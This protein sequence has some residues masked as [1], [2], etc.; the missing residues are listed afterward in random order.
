MGNNNVMQVETKPLTG[1]LK[2]QSDLMNELNVSSENNG[3][4]FTP[5]GK[6]CVLNAI[7]GLVAMTTAQGI[8][9]NKLNAPLLKMALQNVG[10]TELNYSAI[11][12]EVYFDLR[13]VRKD[14]GSVSYVPSIKPQGAGNEKLLR[15][16][17][18][19]LVKDTGL[20]TAWLIREG[21]DYTLPSFN[22]LEMTPPTWT[23]KSFDKKVIMVVYPAQKTDGTVE[24]LYATREGIKPNIIAQI[25]QNTMYAFQKFDGKQKVT[26]EEA[27]N[28]FYDELNK[29]AETHSVDEIIDNPTYAAYINP[30]YTSGG[31]KEQMILRKMK[32]NALKNYPKEY[33]SAAQRDAVE[34]MWEDNDDSLKEKPSVAKDVVAKVEHEINEEP[35]ADAIK[36][37]TV[38]EDGVVNAEN[39][40]PAQTEAPAAETTA[41]EEKEP[42]NEDY[43]F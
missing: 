14:D 9:F 42:A 12:A 37:F 25:R 1:A 30:T 15:K 21:D 35:K 19:G 17:G 29:F 2:V 39:K 11:P 24:Y 33:D 3:V 40:V 43:G 23:P 13:K 31:S 20:K 22:G 8:E 18:V 34:N 4:E 7:A 28:K 10:Y 16:Y 5:Y 27:R 38:D 26:D 6:K 36:D 32:N 41:K